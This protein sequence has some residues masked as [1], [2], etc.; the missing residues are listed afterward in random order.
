MFFPSADSTNAARCKYCEI[1]MIMAIL[2]YKLFHLSV[3]CIV[4]FLCQQRSEER[5][6]KSIT[7]SFIH[8]L[9][10][11]VDSI[12]RSALPIPQENTLSFDPIRS[13]QFF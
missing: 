7:H 2:Q 12:S 11:F 10:G 6:K 3:K 13:I 4:L 1:V 9:F 8:S 5:L